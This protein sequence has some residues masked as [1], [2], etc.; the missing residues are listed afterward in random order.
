[1]RTILPGSVFVSTCLAFLGAGPRRD[2]G[3]GKRGAGVQERSVQETAG[4]RSGYGDLS[5]A[6]GL[7]LKPQFL[8]DGMRALVALS[9]KRCFAP[10]PACGSASIVVA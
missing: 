6:V 1:V 9:A 3:S 8:L 5:A 7:F 10:Y 2:V 4:K